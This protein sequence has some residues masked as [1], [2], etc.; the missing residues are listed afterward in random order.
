MGTLVRAALACH[1]L[2]VAWKTPF[3]SGKDSLNNEFAWLDDQGKKQSIAIPSFSVISAIGQIED[4]AKSVTMD[5]KKSGNALYSIGVTRNEMGGSHLG[6]VL[7]LSGGQVP[8]VDPSMAMRVFTRGSYCDRFRV[9][10]ILP[11][12][13]RR[14]TCCFT[15]RDE[16]CWRTGRERGYRIAGN[17]DV[18]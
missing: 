4:V 10:S 3:I 11:R 5:L 16:L 2:A 14:G 1:D 13:Q 7:G 6:L 15:G 18:R 17:I 9:G 8:T 12:S